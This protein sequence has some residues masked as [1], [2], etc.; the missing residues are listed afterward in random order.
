TPEVADAW[1]DSGAMPYAQFHFPFSTDEE[2]ASRF[3]ADFICEAVDQTR[4]WF[5]TLHALATLLHHAAPEDV[6]VALAYQNV[7]CLGLILDGEGQKM[8]K[9]RGNVV[10][11]WT[12]LN[13]HGADAIRWYMYTASPPGNSRR[14]STDLVAETSRR[15]LSTLWNTYSFFVTYANSA[16]FDP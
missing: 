2:F 6:P 5:Y 3:P 12:V 11:P 7:V 10:D 16:G 13:A 1:F 14:F 8:S 4:G 15:F 9:S